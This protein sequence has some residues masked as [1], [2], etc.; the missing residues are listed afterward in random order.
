MP[1]RARFS[2]RPPPHRDS[3]TPIS[4]HLDAKAGASSGSRLHQLHHQGYRAGIPNR[5]GQDEGNGTL[6]KKYAVSITEPRGYRG[7]SRIG[8]AKGNIRGSFMPGSIQ[9]LHINRFGVI[10]KRHQ[11]GKWRLITD[12]SYPEGRSVNDAIDKSTCSLSYISVRDVANTAVA[13]GR[14]ALIAKTN[15][16][17]AYRL[18]PVQPQDRI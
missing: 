4:R 11:P 9:S 15:I 17:M 12:L 7:V 8:I 16:K 18:V 10:P 3:H 13:L 6:K 5:S 14:G 1:E 2:R